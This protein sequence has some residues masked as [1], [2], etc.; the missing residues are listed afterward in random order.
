MGGDHSPLTHA[1]REAAFRTATRCLI[2]W[3]GEELKQGVTDDRL[4]ELLGRA[5]GIFG[6]SGGPGQLNITYQGSGLKIWASREIHNHCQMKPTF[7]GEFVVKMAREIYGIS[8]PSE[9]QMSMF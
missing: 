3:H 8:D 7:Q 2:A 4:R 5:L 6:G 9:D 1:E